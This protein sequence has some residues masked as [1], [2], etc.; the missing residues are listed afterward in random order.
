[1]WKLCF[2]AIVWLVHAPLSSQEN[3]TSNSSNKSDLEAEFDKIAEDFLSSISLA[4]SETSRKKRALDDDFEL[5]VSNA[6]VYRLQTVVAVSKL[7]SPAVFSKFLNVYNTTYVICATEST[8]STPAEVYIG[9]YK[10]HK[11]NIYWKWYVGNPNGLAAFHFK[12][13][14]YIL[15]ADSDMADGITLVRIDISTMEKEEDHIVHSRYPKSISIWEMK[16]DN[17]YHMAIV[18]SAGLQDGADLTSQVFIYEWM[19]TYFDVYADFLAYDIR[20]YGAVDW[21]FFSLQ[22]KAGQEF[23]LAVANKDGGP[24]DI[25]SVIYKF[26]KDRFVPFQCLP[27]HGAMSIDSWSSE[28]MFLLAVADLDAVYF[29]QYDGWQFV[30]STTQYTQGSMSFGVVHLE[31]SNYTRDNENIIILSVSNPR[32]YSE[33]SVFEIGFKKENSLGDWND[34]STNWC[35]NTFAN[36]E[37]ARTD[38]DLLSFKDVAF[39]D[40]PDPITINGNLYFENGFATDRLETPQLKEIVTKEIYNSDML[41]NLQE[42]QQRLQA[43]SSK[44]DEFEDVLKYSLQTEG[45]QTIYGKLQFQDVAFDCEKK[46]CHF[47][48][49]QTTMLNGEEIGDWSKN[50]VFLDKEQVINGTLSV[51]NIVANN[52][53]VHGRIDG[54]DSKTLVTK[55]GNHQITGLK[56]FVNIFTATDLQVDGL[57]DGVKISPLNILLTTGHQVIT[58]DMT[59]NDLTTSWLEVDSVNGIDLTKFYEDVV[60]SDQPANITGKKIFHDIVVNDLTMTPGST[61]NNIDLA[62]LWDNTFWTDGS[63]KITAPM[64]FQSLNLQKNLYVPLG[65]NGI[66]IPG[67]RVVNVKEG[68]NVTAPHVF[69]TSVAISQLIVL[70]SLNGL[71]TIKIPGMLPQLDIMLKSGNQLITG[72]KTFHTIHLDSDSFVTGTVNGVDL[73]E[74]KAIVLNRDSSVELNR[75][76]TFNNLRIEGPL[77]VTTVAGYN[78][79]SIYEKALK[80]SDTN[81]SEIKFKETIYIEEL[82]SYNINGINVEQDLVLVNKSQVITGTKVFEEMILEDNSVVVNMIN[83][84][85]I[86][87]LTERILKIG[88]QVLNSK[89]FDGNVKINKLTVKGSINNVPISEFVTLS[90]DEKLLHSRELHNV[91]FYEIETNDLQV[92][93]LVN[94]VHIENMMQDTMTYGGHEVVT[95]KKIIK[96]T[97]HVADGDDLT[98]GSINGINI[99]ALWEDAVLLDVPQTISGRKT[100]KYPVTFNNLI[101][102]TIDGVSENDMNN[103]MLKDTPQT[104]QGDVIFLNGFSVKN[105]NLKGYVNGINITDLDASIVKVNEPAT[106]EGPI[107]FESVISKGDVTLTGRIQG[108]DLSEEVVTRFGN[109]EITGVKTF[110]EDLHIEGDTTVGGL[111]DGVSIQDLCQKA[112]FIN[113]RQNIT[114]LTIK[115]DVTFLGGGT[116]EGKVAGFDLVKLHEIAVSTE[117]S[118]LKFSGKKIFENLTIEGTITLEGRFGGEDLKNLDNTYMSLTKD[119]DIPAKME[120]S[121]LTF[122]DTVSANKFNTA[123]QI[124]NGIDVTSL[125]RVLRTDTTQTVTAEHYFDKMTFHGDVFVAGKVND[126]EIPG[127]LMR[128][129]QTNYIH[130]PKAFTKPVHI[131]G[132]LTIAEGKRIQGVDVSK[133]FKTAVLND[134]NSYKI[135]GYKQFYNLS[136]IDARVGGLLDGLEISEKSLLMTYGD[137]VVTGKKTLAGDVN[138]GGSLT[139][140]GLVNGIDLN[141]LSTETLQRGKTNIV[142]GVK[143]FSNPLTIQS[144]EAPTVAGVNVEI[145]EEKINAHLDFELLQNRLEEIEGVVEKMNYAVSK[146]AIVFQYYELFQEFNIPAAYNWLYV[147]GED[148]GE[149]LLLSDNS[150]SR[151]YCS[152]IRLFEFSPEQNILVAHPQ[153]LLASFAVSVK[154]LFIWDTTYLFIANQN[155]NPSCTDGA[156]LGIGNTTSDIYIWNEGFFQLY[157]RL[158]MHPVTHMVVFQDGNLGCAV[159]VELRQCTVFCSKGKNQAFNLLETL[160]TRGGRKATIIQAEE[161]TILVVVAEDLSPRSIYVEDEKSVDIY[162]WNAEQSTFAS[163]GQVIKSTYAQSVLLMSYKTQYASHVFLVI[164]EGRIPKVQNEPKLQIFRYEVSTGIFQKYQEI[165]DYGELD[166]LVLQTG[167]LI[168]FVLDSQM[169]KLKL[170]QHKGASGFVNI[171]TVNSLGSVNFH[172]FIKQADRSGVDHYVALA[173][174]RASMAHPSQGVDYAKILKSKMKGNPPFINY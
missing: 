1:M 119:Q 78:L 144:L 174:P 101:F 25:Q 63:Q 140:N 146:Q 161:D 43:L 97:I 73:S 70:Y 24:S 103:W 80:L 110:T 49:I 100:F 52:I 68:A 9:S 128:R 169:G 125:N 19:G 164:G 48:S 112:T 32:Q 117:D 106:I 149:L 98:V 10:E 139:V 39:I 61:I 134:G 150:S 13:Y 172:A 154:S 129:N 74:L 163:P 127:G 71:E 42:L 62:D 167:E 86:S 102:N 3:S 137:Q 58:G 155:S 5:L 15:V 7:C 77:S 131:L 31:F 157:Q 54:I 165:H 67:P 83:N 136:A 44:I 171:D 69:E 156:S 57:L 93:G 16:V 4:H 147:Y 33:L 96:G 22:S 2:L 6:D 59:F 91:T 99:P 121:S 84:V 111:V 158:E 162:F 66:Q 29:Y 64:T 109:K 170:Y 122:T 142:T 104:V 79:E 118:E 8:A 132:D 50:L 94:G 53:N 82:E 21:E 95:G 152:S 38:P 159:Y 30:L 89:V 75:T 27:T 47:D 37:N 85:N 17:N 105:M 12:E 60:R 76:W 36:V 65:I 14:I 40:Q 107:T 135:D 26:V 153:E 113:E 23:F 145:L 138:I 115:G 34:E 114:H 55:S 166:Y 124:V 51:E 151:S 35:M 90:G 173:G 143:N 46:S 87:F 56:T 168:L 45:N 28:S 11:W 133:W 126:C 20:T 123:N 120:F 72:K 108:V 81:I 41:Q 88:N 18:N 92:E 141:Y 160:P 130:S 148:C 116:I